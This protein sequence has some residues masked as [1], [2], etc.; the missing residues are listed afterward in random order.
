[1]KKFSTF[2]T[3]PHQTW[4]LILT[5]KLVTTENEFGAP[6]NLGKERNTK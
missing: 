6:D 2:L 3:Y 4:C 5:D 1:M